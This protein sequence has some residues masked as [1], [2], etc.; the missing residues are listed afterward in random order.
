M[1]AKIIKSVGF[2]K[3][4]GAPTKEQK[5]ENEYKRIKAMEALLKIKITSEQYK[6][7][8]RIILSNAIDLDM[9]KN[10]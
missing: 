3:I 6:T 10:S 7:I 8:R 2:G 5:M 1:K 9:E 4:R